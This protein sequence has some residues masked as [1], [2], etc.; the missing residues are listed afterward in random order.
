MMAAVS[1][2]T[3]ATFSTADRLVGRTVVTLLGAND[4][5]LADT[6]RIGAEFFI[7]IVVGVAHTNLIVVF[8]VGKPSGRR[9][10]T[11]A[12]QGNGLVGTRTKILTASG[13]TIFLLFVVVAL[14]LAVKSVQAGLSAEKGRPGGWRRAANPFPLNNDT[15]L[16]LRRRGVVTGISWFVVVVDAAGVTNDD[17]VVKRAAAPSF[18]AVF[19]LLAVSGRAAS[20]MAV[21]II[22]ATA[23]VGKPIT[24]TVAFVKEAFTIPSVA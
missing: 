22:V 12:R 17:V 3:P 5:S 24:V 8:T 4:L 6:L 13:R 1:P 9:E 7:A 21:V 18:V 20:I 10:G 2:T 15:A 16:K 14:G 19:R 23:V 11:S